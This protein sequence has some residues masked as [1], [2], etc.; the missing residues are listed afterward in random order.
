MAD[1]NARIAARCAQDLSLFF[2]DTASGLLDDHGRPDPRWFVAD[3][4]HLNAEGYAQWT[5]MLRPLVLRLYAES[6]VPR[7]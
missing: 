3:R 1:A 2:V 4:L 6:G 7:P 5:N